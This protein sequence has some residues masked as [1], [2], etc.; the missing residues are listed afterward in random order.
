MKPRELPSL[1]VHIQAAT[2]LSSSF[3]DVVGAGPSEAAAQEE[4]EY[5]DLDTF[6]STSSLPPLASGGAANGVSDAALAAM[7]PAERR[8]HSRKHS[9]VHARNLSVFFPRPGSEQEAEADRA[10]AAANFGRGG[11]PVSAG[12]SSSEDSLLPTPTEG[13]TGAGLSPSRSRRGHHRRHSVMDSRNVDAAAASSAL[14]GGPSTPRKGLGVQGL[15]GSNPSLLSPHSPHVDPLSYFPPEGSPSSPLKPLTPVLGAQAFKSAKQERR[16][17]SSLPRSDR[18]LMLFAAAHFALGAAL[19][20]AGQS[21]DSLAIGGL[22]Y[23]VVF[24]AL[25]ELCEIGGRWVKDWHR[26]AAAGEGKVYA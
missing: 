2:P 3:S 4:E 9:T 22:G 13:S 10:A 16:V 20:V 24:D 15:N 1:A 11:A 14:A 8:E 23:L 25:G 7:T 12:A 17:I 5:E 19:W 21:G 26:E 18:P 6:D